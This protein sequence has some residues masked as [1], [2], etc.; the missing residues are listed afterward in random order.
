MVV[1]QEL[2]PLPTSAASV[3]VQVLDGGSFTANYNVLHVCS[4]TTYQNLPTAIPRQEV[5]PVD[6][7]VI[8]DLVSIL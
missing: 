7:N 3:E 4:C 6:S 2:P 5:G 1:D 8:L